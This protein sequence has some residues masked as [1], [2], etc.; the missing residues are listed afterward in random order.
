MATATNKIIERSGQTQF[1]ILVWNQNPYKEAQNLF[2]SALTEQ[3]LQAA[4]SQMK[5]FRSRSNV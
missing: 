4:M 5:I 2:I 3:Y 1:L